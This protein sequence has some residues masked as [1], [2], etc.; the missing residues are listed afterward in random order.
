MAAGGVVDVRGRL[1]EAF[2]WRGDRTDK[3]RYADI[4]GWWRDA[5]L[6]GLLGPALAGLFAGAEPTVVLGPDSRGSLVGPLVALHLG[7]GFVEVRK[8]R[9]PAGDSDQWIRRTTPPDY[10]DRHLELGFRRNLVRPADRVLA[11]DDWVDT[12]SQARTVRA[13]VD[14]AGAG[15][16]GFASLVDALDDARLRRDLGLRSLLHLRDL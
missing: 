7:V 10:R 8:D 12:G 13:M 15:W 4:T 1:R 3:S 16:V 9:A 14:G 6:L 2:V 5:E 11:V